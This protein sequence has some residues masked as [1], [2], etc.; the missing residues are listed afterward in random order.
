MTLASFRSRAFVVVAWVGLAILPNQSALALVQRKV[1]QTNFQ[2]FFD[3]LQRRCAYLEVTERGIFEDRVVFLG[4]ISKATSRPNSLANKY[5]T[6][7]GKYGSTSIFNKYGLYGS[8]YSN[9]SPFNK[10][11]L[12]PPEILYKQ[13]NQTYIVGYLTRNRYYV[14]EYA[15]PNVDPTYLFTWLGRVEDLPD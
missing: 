4:E 13:G 2:A 6:Y 7:G 12:N 15:V 10:Y 8:K 9:T 1:D 14:G 3:E 5:G 11:A